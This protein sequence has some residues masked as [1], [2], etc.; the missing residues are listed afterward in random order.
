MRGTWR[1]RLGAPTE[2]PRHPQPAPTAELGAAATQPRLSVPRCD[3]RTPAPR[4]PPTTASRVTVLAPPT[5]LGGSLRDGTLPGPRSS[6]GLDP[7]R[8]RR[9]G[10]PTS[11][12]RLRDG[13][14]HARSHAP[15]GATRPSNTPTTPTPRPACPRP[16]S[17][18]RA[19]TPATAPNAA[20]YRR[21]RLA[22]GAG[23]SD[24]HPTKWRRHHHC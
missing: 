14:R 18:S 1:R 4:S 2:Y 10:T 15:S 9:P 11:T 8:P 12:P 20:K 19:A 6:L 16:P 13:P 22:N 21:R 3:P 5:Q 24:A 17:G 7:S 23:A